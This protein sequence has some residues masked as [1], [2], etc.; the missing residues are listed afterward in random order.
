MPAVGRAFLPLAG[1]WRGRIIQ[2]GAN[3]GV[4]L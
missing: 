4:G 1:S 3:E 2:C